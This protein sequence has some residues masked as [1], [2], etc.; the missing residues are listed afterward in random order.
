MNPLAQ[1]YLP[2]AM[3]FAAALYLGWPPSEPLDLGDDVVSATS[4]RW[5]PQD[6]SSAPRV[7]ADRNP[8]QEESSAVE[9]IDSTASEAEP[10]GPTAE[11]LKAGLHLD[12]IANVGGR[13]WA[14]LNGR[15]RLE[16]DFVHTDDANRHRCQIVSVQPD[17]VAVRYEEIV[18]EIRPS[19]GSRRRSAS[20]KPAALGPDNGGPAARRRPATGR[21]NESRPE[22]FDHDPT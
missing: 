8:F 1:R 21:G 13:T 7:T 5:R 22:E 20:R 9:E 14:I 19:V 6:L 15:P 10:A 12:G 4:V 11:T 17:R 2:P 16:G 3:V 18:M